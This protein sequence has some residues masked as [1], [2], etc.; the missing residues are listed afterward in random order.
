VKYLYRRIVSISPIFQVVLIGSLISIVGYFPVEFLSFMIDKYQLCGDTMA[1]IWC[2]FPLFILFS[3]Y[4]KLIL[5]LGSLFL[6]KLLSRSGVKNITLM[7]I[8][9]A[10]FSYFVFSISKLGTIVSSV[11]YLFLFFIPAVLM[12]HYLI[13]GLINKKILSIRPSIVSL[14]VWTALI[15]FIYTCGYFFQ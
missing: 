1:A 5:I 15:L 10:I 7:F 11:N 13:F 2:T 9:S 3:F 12:V 4:S 14:I 6:F 8:T